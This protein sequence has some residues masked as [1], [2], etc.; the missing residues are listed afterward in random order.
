MRLVVAVF[1]L[2][3]PNVSQHANRS[4]VAQQDQNCISST[5]Q[6]ASISQSVGRF[7]ESTP[8]KSKEEKNDYD[9]RNDV[10][11]R[12]YLWAT[13]IG[14]VGGCFGIGI[15][16]VQTILTR[17]SVNALVA[18]ESPWILV[19][20]EYSPGMS[21]PFLGTSRQ[22]DEPETHHTDFIF[23]FDCVNHGKTPAVITEKRASLI[24]IP[25]NSLPENPNLAATRVFDDRAEPLAAGKDSLTK[26]DEHFSAPGYRGLD[27]WTVLYGV[28]KYRDV[29]GRD[30][31]TTFGYEVTI[32]QKIERLS[33][34]PKYN[35]N[36]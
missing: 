24:I 33:G 25:K 11:Y 10:L 8:A 22:G 16:I 17:S 34:Y 20:I 32:G 29:F 23:R 14:V 27:D 3:I 15:L 30:R 1:L 36:T 4:P 28:V 7:P 6:P 35:E 26:R 5:C 9:P 21:G 19:N 12:R 18:V 2:L 31:Q 13:I